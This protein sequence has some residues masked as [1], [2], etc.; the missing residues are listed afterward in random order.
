[1]SVI[2]CDVD[3]LVCAARVPGKATERTGETRGSQL[4]PK[5]MCKLLSLLVTS[6]WGVFLTKAVVVGRWL[7][8][9]KLIAMAALKLI[10]AKASQFNRLALEF[11]GWGA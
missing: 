10:C 9:L 6:R 3:V 4:S 8:M 5:Y 7:F 11:D 1:M 2:L